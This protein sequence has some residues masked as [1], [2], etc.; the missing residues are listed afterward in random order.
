MM[1]GR[2]GFERMN[3]KESSA[4]FGLYISRM[5]LIHGALQLAL[6]RLH[7]HYSSCIGEC[8]GKEL[9]EQGDVSNSCGLFASASCVPWDLCAALCS[10]LAGHYQT[11]EKEW[12]TVLNVLYT[13]F[14]SYN[15]RH[16]AISLF[17]V[18]HP[19]FSLKKEMAG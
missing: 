1:S 3:V 15:Q 5:I 18:V 12:R 11:P 13:N 10:L 16:D 2:V 17:K 8:T 6:N 9:A 7:T 19:G 4:I 14:L